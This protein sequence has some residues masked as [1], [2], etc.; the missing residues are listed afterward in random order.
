MI[1]PTAHPN[2]A[3]T[4]PPNIVVKAFRFGP[5]SACM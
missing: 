3:P 5:S 4:A 1:A 2:V